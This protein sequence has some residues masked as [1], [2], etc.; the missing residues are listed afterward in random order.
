M[1]PIRPGIRLEYGSFGQAVAT[2][3]FRREYNPSFRDS[4]LSEGR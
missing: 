2:A 1:N 3:L 4:A